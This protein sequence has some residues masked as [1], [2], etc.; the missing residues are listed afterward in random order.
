VAKTI[1][2]QKHM[3]L[4]ATFSSNQPRRKPKAKAPIILVVFE[5]LCHVI[6]FISR[7]SAVFTV[8]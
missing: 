1:C 3:F 5:M 8:V 4:A 6:K 7:N 2:D